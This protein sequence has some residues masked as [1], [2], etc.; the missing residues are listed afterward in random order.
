M[1][2][3]ENLVFKERPVKKLTEQYVESYIVEEVI[4]RN[5][6]YGKVETANFYED[7][8]SGKC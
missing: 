4:S 6:K 5:V 1:L 3:S 7:S 8:S 2:S